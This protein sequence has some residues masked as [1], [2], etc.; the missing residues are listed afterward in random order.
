MHEAHRMLYINCN[1]KIKKEK[2][3]QIISTKKTL[4]N[5]YTFLIHY[6]TNVYN[7]K[8]DCSVLHHTYYIYIYM[9]STLQRSNY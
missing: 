5:N 9:L 7:Q 6:F 4:R 3:N 1:L 8:S 2:K